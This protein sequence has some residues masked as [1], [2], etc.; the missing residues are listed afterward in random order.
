MALKRGLTLKDASSYNIQFHEGRPVL[1]DTLSFTKY[2]EGAP[3][4]A[5]RQFCQ[6]FLAPLALM[7][8]RDIRLAALLRTNIDGIPLD[9]A[10]RLLPKLT[11]LSPG[12]M[13]HIHLH[14]R[15][16]KK[17]EDSR[18]TGKTPTVSQNALRGILDNLKGIISK[19]EWRPGGTEWGEY[20]ED[21]NYT[22][23]SLAAKRDLVGAMLDK[24]GG[25]TVWD[26]GAN[27]GFFSRVASDKGWFT[28]A[29]DIDPTAV[30]ENWRACRRGGRPLMLPLVMDLTNPSPGLGWAH[31]ERDSFL[32]RGPADTVIALALIHHLAISNNV[33]LDRLAEFFARAGRHLIIEFVPKSDSQVARLLTTR[34]DVFPS[35]HL[36]GFEQI[37]ADRFETL[38]KVSIIGSERTLF[39]L[40]RK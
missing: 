31:R 22:D 26:V 16:Q 28:V 6:H 12:L 32:D 24:T 3:W 23:A 33:P 13:M 17:H 5:Y 27:N 18:S 1:I 7:A 2:V 20:Y 37:F 40:R 21:T 15:S 34:E 4:V 14:A 25:G 11:R 30:E 35:Y 36:E 38:D 9:L 29:A 39:L 19:L 10:S 8:K